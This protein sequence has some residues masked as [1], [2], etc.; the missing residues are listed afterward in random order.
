MTTHR[1][2][3]AATAFGIFLGACSGSP[4]AGNA[5]EQ[6]GSANPDVIDTNGDHAA[7]PLEDAPFTLI[8][9]GRFNEPWAMVFLPNSKLALIT[10]R[11]GKLK[12]WDDSGLVRD[13]AGVPSVKYA[14]QGGLGD[15]ILSPDFATS[16]TIYLSWVEA[17]SGNTSG[18]VVASAKLLQ[19]DQPRLENIN[20]IWRQNPKVT[21]DGHFSHRLAFSPDGQHLFIGS[22]ERQKFTPAQDMQS[23]LGKILRIN[24]DGSL[25][26]DNPFASQGG[27]AAEI[28]SL[29]HRN[30]L[31][32]AFDG[33][34]LLWNQEMGP[35]GG[36]EVNL[37]QKG[38]NYGYPEVS[39]GDHYDGR[40]I[41]NHDTRPEFAAPKLWWNPAVSPSGLVYYGGDLYQGWKD[42]LLMG[43]LS[44]EGLLRMA[45]NGDQIS[46]S[47]RWDLGMR[48]REVGVRSDGSIWLLSDG[49]D[50]RLLK[51]EPKP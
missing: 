36:D 13:V 22:G 20:I 25:P 6:Q 31:G 16:G 35:K 50:G 47:D 9:A 12:L 29:G 40:P 43:A 24:P 19:G 1:F 38:A 46:K 45:I 2:L 21:G 37:V 11:A 23:N 4:S 41:P 26:A 3:S 27:V 44:G 15:V 33:D 5:A 32:I 30:I 7:T 18:S 10:E 14:G 39:N 49:T 48:I 42:S 8:E 28:W 34:G 51:L 17:G